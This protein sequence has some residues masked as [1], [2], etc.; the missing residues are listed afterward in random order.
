M[1]VHQ[2]LTLMQKLQVN[3][4]YSASETSDGGDYIAM[5]WFVWNQ[6]GGQVDG[7]VF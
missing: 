3:L 1:E 2:S 4:L 5:N 6:G 7:W